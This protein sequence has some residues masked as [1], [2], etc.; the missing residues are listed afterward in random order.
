MDWMTATEAEK[1]EANAIAWDAATD[2]VR[3]AL[4]RHPEMMV[5]EAQLAAAKD[6]AADA[7]ECLRIIKVG[8]RTRATKAQRRYS[9]WARQ[10][11]Y[12]L[13]LESGFIFDVDPT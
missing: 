10:S 5:L 9:D 6:I 8:E 13:A 12:R 7:A 11:F 3:Q 2:R 1:E 4:R